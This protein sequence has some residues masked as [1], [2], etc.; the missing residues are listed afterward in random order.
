MYF[1][2]VSGLNVNED[3]SLIYIA[4]VDDETGVRLADAVGFQ[5]GNLPMK[6]LGVSLTPNKWNAYDCQVLTEKITRKIAH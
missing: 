3:K 2:E 6:Y 1:Y 4:G 5:M